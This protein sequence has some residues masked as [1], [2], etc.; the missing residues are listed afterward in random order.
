MTYVI[1][2][3]CVGTSW[4]Y[5]DLADGNSWNLKESRG[6][7]GLSDVTWSSNSEI[8]LESSRRMCWMFLEMSA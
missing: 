4:K 1:D 6:I 8:M 2:D 3:L 5:I 7:F